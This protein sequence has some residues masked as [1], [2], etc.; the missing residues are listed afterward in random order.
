[1]A[2][3]FTKVVE[4]RASS[5]VPLNECLGQAQ[6]SPYLE[7]ILRGEVGPVNWEVWFQ[8]DNV[9]PNIKITNKKK[10]SFS[11]VSPTGIASRGEESPEGGLGPGDFWLTL[12]CAIPQEK[13]FPDLP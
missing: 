5:Q 7:T 9:F 13:G 10:I 6:H 3:G 1:M 8:H 4:N 12:S 11:T 2:Y